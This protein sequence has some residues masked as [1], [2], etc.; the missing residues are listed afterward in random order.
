MEMSTRAYVGVMNNGIIKAVYNHCDGY[1]FHLGE[2]LETYFSNKSDALNL[3]SMGGISYVDTREGVLNL[4]KEHGL[5]S[6]SFVN[7][8]RKCMAR[9]YKDNDFS[10]Y[11]N[12]AEYFGDFCNSNIEFAYLL[13]NGKWFCFDVANNREINI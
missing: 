12:K 11:K 5:P 1:P 7:V 2:I 4:I 8:S 13:E 9:L 6:D 10:V 3:I